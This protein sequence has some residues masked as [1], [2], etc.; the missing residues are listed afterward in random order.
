MRG[1]SVHILWHEGISLG[2]LVA[3]TN[4]SAELHDLKLM[5]P[6]NKKPGYIP[7][8]GEKSY[9]VLRLWNGRNGKEVESERVEV[10]DVVA[11]EPFRFPD[12]H[13]ILWEFYDG[14][15]EIWFSLSILGESVKNGRVHRLGI[16]FDEDYS[17]LITSPHEVPLAIAKY[18]QLKDLY[19]TLNADVLRAWSSCAVM[20]EEDDLDFLSQC[21]RFSRR[22]MQILNVPM[23]ERRPYLENEKQTRYLDATGV[24]V[25]KPRKTKRQPQ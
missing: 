1:T 2:T 12:F 10:D 21:F 24:E 7:G 3:G 8:S 22:G 13:S 20:K 4:E 16:G 6:G 11:Y 15:G 25:K 5:P 18:H 19:S 9:T 17:R 14:V 23:E